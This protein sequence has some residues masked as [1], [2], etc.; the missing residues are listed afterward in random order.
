LS[1][2]EGASLPRALRILCFLSL[3]SLLA[4][5]SSASAQTSPPSPFYARANTFAVFGAYS[6]DSSHILMGN[7]ENRKLLDF[8]VSFNRRLFLDRIVNWQYSGELLPVA[9]ES[10][11][12]GHVVNNQT[13]PTVATYSENL[14]YA[15]L[16]CAPLTTSYNFTLPNQNGGTTTY[17]GTETISCSGRQWTIGEAISPVGFQWNFLP[18]RKTQ[19][20]FSGHGGYM[21]STR[22]IPLDSAGSFNFTFDLGA[23]VELYRSKTRS[24]RA[25]YR[26]HH[27]SNHG[28]ATANPG[29]DN[30]LFQLTYAFGR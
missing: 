1:K 15:E 22:A 17:T 23:G 21:Y 25:E 27:I 5:A 18:R 12:L 4:G 20:F 14:F 30:G 6:G 9:L 2:N 19:P 7:A 13:S 26:Y 28:T 8:G 10:D 3:F 29:I 24:I 11:P 16:S